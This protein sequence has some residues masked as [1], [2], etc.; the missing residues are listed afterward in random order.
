MAYHALFP[1]DVSDG[2]MQLTLRYHPFAIGLFARFRRGKFY[3]DGGAAVTIDRLTWAATFSDD[4]R[5]SLT[6]DP[7]RWLVAVSPIVR[8]G[9]AVAEAY[10]LTLAVGAEVYLNE[11]PSYIELTDGSRWTIVDPLDVRPF[12]YAGIQFHLF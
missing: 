2:P 6:G 1:I 10:S 3:L 12:F 4:G 5:Y 7:F 11:S 8:F 9:W